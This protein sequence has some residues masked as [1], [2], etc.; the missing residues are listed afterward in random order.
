MSKVECKPL[1]EASADLQVLLCNSV[2]HA[3]SGSQVYRAATEQFDRFT[4][5]QRKDQTFSAILDSGADVHIWTLADAEDLFQSKG[6]SNLKV[7]GVNGV[8]ARADLAGHLIVV[9]RAPSGEQYQIDLGQAH[10]MRSCPMNLLSVSLLIQIGAIIHFEKDNCW[11]KAS[12]GA[13]QIPFQQRDGLFHLEISPP[14]A[15]I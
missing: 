6:V 3:T 4:A 11:F 5:R 7:I 2:F 10:A 15:W 8:P 14:N 1:V 13:A 12:A 9:V